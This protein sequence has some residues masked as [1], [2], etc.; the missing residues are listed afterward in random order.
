LSSE[1]Y[2]LLTDAGGYHTLTANWNAAEA[3]SFIGLDFIGAKYKTLAQGYDI[4][5]AELAKR[6]TAGGGKIW[7]LSELIKF[8]KEQDGRIKL[9]FRQRQATASRRSTEAAEGFIEV[10]AK[11]LILAMPR[12]SLE[13]LELHGTFFDLD[14]S[15]NARQREL[16]ESVLS[17]PAFK[18]FMGFDAPWWEDWL[19]L[20]SGRSVCDLPIR[21]TYYFG[22]SEQTRHSLLMTSYNDASSVSFWKGL[23]SEV[24]EPKYISPNTVADGSQWGDTFQAPDRMVE[25][26]RLQLESLHGI[27]IPKPISS[28]Y[29]DWS[30]EPF[31]AGWFLWKAGS[32]SWEVMPAIRCP[33]KG[34][35]PVYI[36]GDGYSSLQ[37]WV[38]GALNTAEKMLQ[39]H[40]G[41]SWPDWLK[42]DQDQRPYLGE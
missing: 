1:A 15:R 40:F 28:C 5:A 32:K 23:K 24:D 29:K 3:A 34:E 42:D 22:T 17:M 39:E 18:L 16:V 38:E 10:F 11:K 12:H 4:Q 13:R 37:G 35:A 7:G 27:D 21:Q 8:D 41:L 36:C 31:G 6:F 2:N 9:T 20:T 14:A 26:A 30:A 33:W 19:A 25:H